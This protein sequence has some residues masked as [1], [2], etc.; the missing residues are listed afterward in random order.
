[1]KIRSLLELGEFLD[2]ELSW[3][4]KE[5]T[6]IKLM[7]RGL[8]NHERNAL[9][10]AA[11]CLLYAHWEG[12]IKAATISYVTIVS[13]KGLRYCDLAP[14]FVALGLRGQI[15]ESGMSL[16]P[17]IHTKLVRL[18]VSGLEDHAIL[19]PETAVDTTSNLNFE[20]FDEVLCIL[21]LERA[22]YMLQKPLIDERLLKNRNAVAHGDKVSIDEE[23]YGELHEK[24]IAMID[25]FRDA[26]QNAAALET[27]RR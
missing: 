12:F 15:R 8:R 21:G 18:L 5:L 11:I 7:L 24:M 20:E 2:G 27:Y 23:D 6:T 19:S 9:L 3:R 1:M 17:S 22:P 4:K 26:V 10:R 14:N 16:K 25:T 13:R